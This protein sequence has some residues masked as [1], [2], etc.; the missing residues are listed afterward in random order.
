MVS[1][2]VCIV[3]MTIIMRTD[4]STSI[5]ALTKMFAELVVSILDTL[6]MVGEIKFILLQMSILSMV[7]IHTIMVGSKYIV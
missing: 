5:V 4:V 6:V 2:L 3:I 7:F 1:W